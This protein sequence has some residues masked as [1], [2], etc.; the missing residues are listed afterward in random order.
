MTL[1]TITLRITGAELARFVWLLLCAASVTLAQSN[2][3]LDSLREHFLASARQ[4]SA[5]QPIPA[6]VTGRVVSI[7]DSRR[8]LYEAIAQRQAASSSLMGKYVESVTIDDGQSRV[9]AVCSVFEQAPQPRVTPGE[10]ITVSGLFIGAIL[11]GAVELIQCSFTSGDSPQTTATAGPGGAQRDDRPPASALSRSAGGA[12]STAFLLQD[13][14]GDRMQFTRR[15]AGH[16]LIV[17][18]RVGWVYGQ[19]SPT[20]KGISLTARYDQDGHVYCTLNRAD[21]GAIQ[22]VKTDQ[23]ITVSA[24]F[25]IHEVYFQPNNRYLHDL[26][27]ENCVV[28]DYNPPVPADLA[29]PPLKPL[30]PSTMP[31][32]GLFWH[33]SSNLIVGA[34]PSSYTTWSFYFFTPDGHVY[35][36]FPGNGML[37]HFDFAAAAAE[38]AKHTG[39][40]RVSGSTIEFAWAGGSQP[41]TSEFHKDGDAYQFQGSSWYPVDLSRARQSKDWLIGAVRKQIG[42]VMGN[43]SALVQSWY[44]F[45]PDGTFETLGTGVA[46]TGAPVP[47]ANRSSSTKGSGT[48]ELFGTTLLLHYASGATEKHTAVPYGKGGIIVDGSLYIHP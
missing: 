35:S 26:S 17:T 6:N 16:R 19:T 38:D 40:Y 7:D 10:S 12:V 36:Q 2:G 18:G 5:F 13:A 45:R 22:R 27:M 8:S 20:R 14:K 3:P 30:G 34:M 23:V 25:D 44:T 47:Q 4:R 33:S 9:K 43:A 31:L 39:Y 15:Y 11:P 21:F 48:Y 46:L 24:A 42:A 1:K 28:T 41:E 37:D 32:S 29:F